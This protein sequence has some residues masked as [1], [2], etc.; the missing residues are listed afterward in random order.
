MDRRQRRRDAD[1]RATGR[2][3]AAA[4]AG[5]PELV[6][7]EAI[8]SRGVVRM[9]GEARLVDRTT[10]RFRVADVLEVHQRRS[11]VRFHA[12]RPIILDTGRGELPISSIALDLGGGGILLAGPDYLELGA[13]AHFVLRL[14]RDGAPIVGQGRVVRID[15]GA[16]ARLPSTRSPTP[17][18]S[19]CRLI[20]DRERAARRATRDV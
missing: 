16:D 14:E 5:S 12:P 15:A 4:A 6:S 18:A 2:V 10:I 8:S 19:A 7:L 20:F 1:A 3:R 9:L 17:T 11:H 13:R